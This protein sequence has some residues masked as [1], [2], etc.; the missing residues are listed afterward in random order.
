[1][2]L[3]AAV[4]AAQ[5]LQDTIAK[6]L[7]KSKSASEKLILYKKYAEFL[8][9][10]DFDRSLKLSRE[11]FKLAKKFKQK[12]AEAEFLRH[13]GNAYYFSG[14]LDSASTFY[15]QALEILK[16]RQAPRELAEL[17]NNL[18]RFYR[19]TGDYQ[20]SLRN[21]DSALKIYTDLG[22]LEGI[23]TIYNESGVVYEYLEK[24]D[25]AVLRYQKSLAIQRKRGDLVGQGYSLEFIGG[26]FMLQ[27]KLALAEKYL[28]ASIKVR[29]QTKDEFALAMSYN[30]LG[31]LYQEQNRY[32]EAEKFLLKS[33]DISRR[34]NYLD[35]QK[36]NY[37]NLAKIYRLQNKNDKAYISLQNFRI[38][39]DSI[40]TLGKAEQIE[41]LSV[42]YET[43]EKDRQLLA[44]KSKVLKR[45]VLVFSLLGVLLLAFFYYQNFRARQKVQLQRA[46]LHQQELAANAVM[47]AEDN[48]RK[49]MATQLHDGIGQLLSAANMNL[50]VLNEFK[51]DENNF[52]TILRKTQSVLSDAIS[53]VR[54][55]SHQIMPNMLIRS[56]L[57]EALQDI[58]SKTES[59]GLTIDL[60]ID[61]VGKNLNQTVQVVLFRVIQEC[62]HNTI[63]HAHASQI[64][65]SLKQNDDFVEVFYADNGVGFDVEKVTEAGGLGVENIRSR[66]KM[67]KGTY[68]LQSEK[69]RGTSVEMKIPC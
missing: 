35:L 22:D 40:F 61:G 36:D 41:E 58:V 52:R 48:E 45:N 42:K 9:T 39:N 3:F 24:H 28:L 4:S 6:N 16:N 20:R 69:N 21:Y 13:R 2:I 44:E 7:E 30:V 46:V 33:N 15:Y 62:L 49:R 59:P 50:S 31:K 34:L 53:D 5:N 38:I 27:K 63:K 25:E 43:A 66:I 23:A 65:I 51:N 47:K 54:T 55:L 17:Y 64:R 56:T 32:V 68:R 14:K 60:Q 10:K 8:E 19:K 18:G 1:M 57:P 12:T 37:D 11:G 26:N 67:L 29:E